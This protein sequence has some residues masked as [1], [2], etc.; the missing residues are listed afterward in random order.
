MKCK[1]CG[2]EMVLE[3]YYID[4]LNNDEEICLREQFGCINC[5]TTAIKRTYYK[6]VDEEVE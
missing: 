5:D 3:E 1:N 2:E 6:K 4:F